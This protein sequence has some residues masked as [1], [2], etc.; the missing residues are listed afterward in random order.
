MA[1][2]QDEGIYEVEDLLEHK[3]VD[4][5]DYF[6][7]KWKGYGDTSWEPNENIGEELAELKE[8]AKRGAGGQGGARKRKHEGKKE[9]KDKKEKRK[10]RRD[11]SEDRKGSDSDSSRDGQMGGMMPGMMPGMHGMPHGMPGMMPGMMPGFPPDMGKGMMMDP[12]MM[13]GKGFP[14]KG[15]PPGM[16]MD[17]MMMKGK[18][19][20]PMM[21]GKG[22]PMPGPPG[23]WPY[24]PMMKGMG[25]PLMGKGMMMGKGHMMMKGKGKP[26]PEM[27]PMNSQ[28]LDMQ[29]FAVEKKRRLRE[30]AGALHAA[31]AK[32]AAGSDE[33]KAKRAEQAKRTKAFLEAL[34]LQLEGHQLPMLANSEAALA[35]SLWLTCLADPEDADAE[36]EQELLMNVAKLARV[37][38]A[39]ARQLL[40]RA[41]KDV[42]PSAS[43]L[44]SGRAVKLFK[45]LADVLPKAPAA[46]GGSQHPPGSPE[47]WR[48]L[49]T[50]IY[51]VHNPAKLGD[52]D[53]LLTKYRGRERTLYLGICEK[54]K[55]PPTFGGPPPPGPPGGPPPGWPGAP[56]GDVP[57][58]PAQASVTSEEQ[59]AKYRALIVEIYQEHNPDKLDG[60]DNLLA[61]YRGREELV[62]R[63]I[64]TKYQI[65]PKVPSDGNERGE[66]KAAEDKKS[67]VEKYKELIGE[68]YAEHNKEKLSE[69]DD[70]LKKYSGKE[71]T[72]YLAV[73]KKY[74]IEPKTL[75]DEK[76]KKKKEATANGEDAEKLAAEKV[77]KIKPLICEIYQE[78]NPAKL[79][80][81]EELLAK[82]KGREEQLYHGVCEK[83][84]VEP[85]IPKVDPAAPPADGAL[86][87]PPPPS[88]APPDMAPPSM[89]PPPGPP[90]SGAASAQ[91]VREA[92][93]ELIRELYKEHN[94]SKLDSVDGL[95]NKYVGQEQDLYLTICRKYSVTPKDPLGLGSLDWLP[96]AEAQLPKM[97]ERFVGALVLHG[98]G[99]DDE[100]VERLE[101]WERSKPRRPPRRLKQRYSLAGVEASQVDKLVKSLQGDGG[102]K[103]KLLQE[104]CAGVELTLP[105]AD[106]AFAAAADTRSH[107]RGREAFDAAVLHLGEA[108]RLAVKD[109]AESDDEGIRRNDKWLLPWFA[110]EV[111]YTVD[112]SK[113]ENGEQIDLRREV[114]VEFRRGCWQPK[115]RLQSRAHAAH[116]SLI[117]PDVARLPEIWRD[118]ADRLWLGVSGLVWGGEMPMEAIVTVETTG[119]I[120]ASSSCPSA[121]YA[122]GP[123]PPGAWVVITAVSEEELDQAKSAVA[124]VLQRVLSEL[125]VNGLFAQSSLY[126]PQHRPSIA[127]RASAACG[128]GGASG[129]GGGSSSSSSE[130]ESDESEGV[131]SDAEPTENY[132][133]LRLRRAEIRD[134]YLQGLLCLNCDAADHKH[135]DCTIRRK[136]CWNCHGNHAGNDCPIRCRFCKDRHDY[137]L[138]ECVKRVCRRVN[139][140]KKSKSAQDQ[141]QCISNFEQLMI[142]LE[143]FDDIDLA[144]HNVDVQYLVKGLA[145]MN[146]LFPVELSDLTR[147][148]LNMQPPKRRA[149]DEM[150]IPPP[151]SGQ[152]P[153]PYVA[154]RLPK[155][156]PPPMPENKYP[157]VEKIF[158]DT[159]LAKGTYGSNVLSR[160]IG[161][162]G[163]NHRRMET[164][165]GARVFFRGLGV[166]GRDMELNDPSDARLH[167]SVKGDVPA[168][169]Q[170][171]K[172]ILKEIFTELDSDILEKGEVG[173]LIDRPR[174]VDRHPFGFLLA[175][176]TTD[177]EYDEALKFKF[178][179]EDGQTLNDLLVWL[180]QAKLPL[181]LD[182]DTQWR[183]T[184]QITPAEPAQPDD[185]PAEAEVVVSA[186]NRLLAEWQYPCPYWFEEQD[187]RPTGLWTSLTAEDEGDGE[188]ACAIA[189]QQGQGVRLSVQAIAHFAKL[190]EQAGLSGVSRAVAID[191]LA[192][193]RGVVRRK[194][195]DEQLLLYLQYPWAF[196]A[197]AMGRGLKLPFNRE[198]V[199]RML[200]DLG[201]VG[202]KPTE[203]AT[204]PPFRGFIVEWMPLKGVAVRP[205]GVPSFGQQPV[206]ALMAAPSQAQAAPTAAAH[207]AL[208][209]LGVD[210][211][212]RGV[213]K[214]Y[215]PENIFASR[216]D[217]RELLAGPGG[218]HF[219]HVLKKFPNAVLT[220]EGQ[221]STA[222]PPAHRLHVMMSSE[223]SE[224]FEQASADVLDLVETVCD[225]VG[226]ELGMTEEQVE[227]LIR[228][229]RPEKYFEAHGIRTPLAPNRPSAPPPP[230]AS[231]AL[232]AAPSAAA[233]APAAAEGQAADFEFVDDDVDMDG[234]GGALGGDDTEDED[235]RTEASDAVSALSDADI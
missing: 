185:A 12:M 143:G 80:N 104:K 47:Y 121:P 30:L 130:A 187:L 48:D 162:G 78:H 182:S 23:A 91:V 102:A 200:V 156:P 2:E 153:K 14:G 203:S 163:A 232:A 201:R 111:V 6:L 76:K 192:R 233:G 81:V 129:A 87:P 5:R 25:P 140:W 21:P 145:E 147:T 103:W 188:D 83:Y 84:N 59:V 216:Q 128:A 215:L 115:K 231:H 148:I 223:D 124:P 178:P 100:D 225:M 60:V 19:M 97:L 134:A 149:Q 196:F 170:T 99:L 206:A 213:C 136:V 190:L 98:S 168:Q 85:K 198:Q 133:P 50:Q 146:S 77:A 177:S 57:A 161:R 137:P 27:G 205:D 95:L 108:L 176:G 4:G 116:H 65:E 17:P 171:V 3:V 210:A 141:R 43:C 151:P 181:E 64:C 212:P 72:L 58:P 183:T 226:E 126:M 45:S 224:T 73:C 16:M 169:G 93:S 158:L 142:K 222:V 61:K 117:G 186:F 157:W 32:D 229:V 7:V 89:A 112:I 46:A 42:W 135:Q 179:E 150:A 138:L 120:Q 13:M 125:C 74:N 92:Y 52:V 152:P 118:L 159:L 34:G 96:K 131:L 217:L 67:A 197:E 40:I 39:R 166:S 24:D 189:L 227:G 107:L 79:E 82:Y 38:Q 221:P 208:T 180:K 209:P 173:P 174:D 88:M 194:A 33:E 101:D 44:P 106:G 29:R 127:Y 167:I 164:E 69:L 207:K 113:G 172:R 114:G 53:T 110:E 90:P 193:L 35:D 10:K 86:P 230:A 94:P 62:Y 204:A 36:E 68:V 218:A 49:V 123:S 15:M 228:D 165:S 75:K 235:A 51:S 9:K 122:A 54:Y 37:N 219:G 63:G 155:D 154:P 214:Y 18:G 109:A 105:E 71:K 66:K 8:A 175:K 184:L 22:G 160:I 199:H 220:T 70:I 191:V 195:A 144:K 1:E 26:Y 119:G 55:V 31:M 28:A 41:C 211:P 139:D 202:G 132:R 234:Q 20:P 56:G 11:S